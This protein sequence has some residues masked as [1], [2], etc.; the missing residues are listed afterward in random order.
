MN[1]NKKE[2]N[3]KFNKVNHSTRNYK[4]KPLDERVGFDNGNTYKKQTGGAYGSPSSQTLMMV[5]PL[6]Q[7]SQD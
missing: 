3:P 2:S 1:P 4:N 5:T 6:D 7:T